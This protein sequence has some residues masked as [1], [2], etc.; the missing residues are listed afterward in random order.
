MNILLLYYS[1]TFNTSFLVKKVKEEFCDEGHIV[2][3]IDVSKNNGKIQ[4]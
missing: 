4:I 3:A 2:D 1:G